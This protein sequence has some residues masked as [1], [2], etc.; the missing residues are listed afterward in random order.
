MVFLVIELKEWREI[1]KRIFERIK[2]IISNFVRYNRI[3]AFWIGMLIIWFLSLHIPKGSDVKE[4]DHIIELIN[5]LFSTTLFV[6]P[7]IDLAG[8][9]FNKRNDE[10]ISISVNKYQVCD[11]VILIAISTVIFFLNIRSIVFCAKIILV[12][13]IINVGFK[14]IFGSETHKHVHFINK[15][16]IIIFNIILSM[17]IPIIC[18][19]YPIK[20]FIACILLVIFIRIKKVIRKDKG[21]HDDPLTEVLAYC[22]IL[23]VY[24]VFARCMFEFDPDLFIAK[25]L[26]EKVCSKYF[27]IILPYLISLYIILIY[28]IFTKIFVTCYFDLVMGYNNH[29]MF[30]I[31]RI[32]NVWNFVELI[33]LVVILNVF[34]LNKVGVEYILRIIGF[35]DNIQLYTNNY[36]NLLLEVKSSIIQALTTVTLIM[37]YLKMRGCE[38]N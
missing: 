14:I 2:T 6:V 18:L 38:E 36:E 31:N 27:T 17:S 19:L 29:E 22:G 21:Y 26:A 7:I 10:E 20:M 3:V 5:G 15:C 11:D 37:T 23:F 1:M 28:E 13:F 12:L 16:K 33:I 4:Y 34:N 8:L 24:L 32:N 25:S 9:L 35:K 30:W